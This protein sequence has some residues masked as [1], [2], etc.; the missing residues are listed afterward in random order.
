MTE[1]PLSVGLSLNPCNYTYKASRDNRRS[2]RGRF[3]VGE[4]TVTYKYTI[5][6]SLNKQDIECHVNIHVPGMLIKFIQFVTTGM[7]LKNRQKA[8]ENF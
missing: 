8:C 4:S 5:G 3:P 2:N 7:I 1:N 6:H